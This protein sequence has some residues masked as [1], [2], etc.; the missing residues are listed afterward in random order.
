MAFAD[1]ERVVTEDQVAH[2]RERPGGDRRI[3]GRVIAT[4]G[5]SD[6]SGSRLAVVHGDGRVEGA[7]LGDYGATWLASAAANLPAGTASVMSLTV[8]GKEVVEAGLTCGGEVA[9]LLQPW[10]SVPA[11]LWENFEQRAPVALVT[12]L[13]GTGASYLVTTSGSDALGVPPVPSRNPEAWQLAADLLAA[14]HSAA[15]RLPTADG[16]VVV[17]AW[18]PPPRLVIVGAGGI[19]EALDAQATLLGWES[20]VVEDLDGVDAVLDWAGAS[21]A[22]VVLTHDP[23]LDGPALARGLGRRV[24]YVGALGSRSTQS[25][26]TERMLADG[27]PAEAI[28][29]IHRPIGLDLGGRSGPEVALAICAEILA[30]RC[31]RDA[32]P[33]RTATGPINDRRAA[34][35]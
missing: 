18:V 14:G 7:W 21:A 12:A 19:A 10:D 9:V 4:E 15:R 20:W 25:K 16:E 2:G 22:L 11:A 32:R 8:Q 26:R 34:G 27:V 30:D 3:V 29:R 28:E 35:A 23:H 24:A 31:G 5:F 6:W 17:E 33:L 13:D 1:G